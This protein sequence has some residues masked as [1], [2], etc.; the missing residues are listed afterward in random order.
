MFVTLVTWFICHLV[1]RKTQIFYQ[2]TR[3]WLGSSLPSQVG[4]LR[5]YTKAL[6][7]GFVVPLL[8]SRKTQIFYQGTCGW[9]GLSFP[10]QV[11][12]LRFFTKALMSGLVHPSICGQEDLDLSP[13][14]WWVAQFVPPPI[15]RMIRIFY[16]GTRG[17]LGW[18]LHSSV[19]N[20]RFFTKALV[21]G[22]VCPSIH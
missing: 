4:R 14:H 16:Q 7:G 22:L 2:G 8:I 1:G 18:S 9:L 19:G 6:T 17:W 21:S 15:S 3:R 11:G 13:R 10:L 5:S 20:L 12:R